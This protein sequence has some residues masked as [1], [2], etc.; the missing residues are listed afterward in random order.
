MRRKQPVP[1]HLKHNYGYGKMLLFALRA[2]LD[3]LFGRHDHYGTRRTHKV[4]IRVFVHF[5]R[6]HD[7]RD[8]RQID[9]ELVASYGQYLRHRLHQSYVWPNGQVDEPI[10]VAY[11]HNLISTLNTTLYALRRRDD[12]KISARAALGI[13]RSNI[14]KTQIQADISDVDTAADRM[15]AS[16]LSRGAAVVLL[17]R[18]WG[19]RV[20]E[21]LLQDL[22]RMQTEIDQAGSAAILEGC[23][24]GRRCRTRTIR[25]GILQ[26]RALDFARSV[27]PSDSRC[28]LSNSDTV[29]S[30]LQTTLSRC[31]RILRACGIPTFR[32]LRAGF[33]QDVYEAIVRGPSP[34][35]GP[36]RDQ[37]LDRIAR[38]EVARLLGHARPQVANS[39]IGGY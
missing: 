26:R 5:C 1:R 24:G 31:R 30:F 21:A 37:V 4:R 28:L 10:S 14:R 34:L 23:K 2:A 18:A 20:Q 12:L 36:I 38:A 11:A 19:M 6:Q 9:R 8:A 33:A 27:R 15:V 3:A 17:A 13:S 25:A 16:G 32:E 22:D 39:Y 7:I 29:R 35:R